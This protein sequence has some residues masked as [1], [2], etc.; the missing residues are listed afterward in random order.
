MI[1][2]PEIMNLHQVDMN[3]RQVDMNLHQVDMNLHQA[4]MNLR[5]VDTNTLARLGD[6]R[7]FRRDWNSRMCPADQAPFVVSKNLPN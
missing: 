6:L 4:D 7:R 5:Q 2:R 1:N 3:F